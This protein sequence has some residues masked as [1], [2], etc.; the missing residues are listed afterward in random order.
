MLLLAKAGDDVTV[1][2]FK[3]FYVDPVSTGIIGVHVDAGVWH[4]PAF[5]AASVASGGR[6]LLDNRQGKVHGC[7]A[8]DFVKEF[9]GYLRV[10]LCP[11]Q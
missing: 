4:Q 6:L 8:V 3:A 2:S 11:A 9:G 10:P 7:V 5:P 1:E